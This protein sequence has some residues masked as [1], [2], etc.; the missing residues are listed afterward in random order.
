MKSDREKRKQENIPYLLLYRELLNK[1]M[2][3]ENWHSLATWTDGDYQILSDLILEKTK[4]RLSVSS[5]KRVMGKEETD[6]FPNEAT[7]NILVN[8]L[9]SNLKT[10]EEFKEK[11]IKEQSQKEI[12]VEN[13]TKKT[14]DID[15]KSESRFKKTTSWSLLA[16]GL[17]VA[18]AIS[19][20]VG[21]TVKQKT[22]H[23]SFANMGFSVATNG[24]Q[25]YCSKDKVAILFAV[26]L[27]GIVELNAY[28]A[29]PEIDTSYLDLCYTIESPS[30]NRIIKSLLRRS[31]SLWTMGNKDNP[32]QFKVDY[33]DI[34][35]QGK[36]SAVVD[37]QEH[38]KLHY[39]DIIAKKES[40]NYNETDKQRHYLV[41]NNGKWR[42]SLVE[43]NKNG[44][45]YID[46]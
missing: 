3:Q 15:K 29:L 34:V 40:Q 21:W 6:S 25:E 20:I 22:E 11:I 30:R 24:K 17:F 1:A 19:L 31:K 23:I 38:W 27:V 12:I 9:D 36:D 16:I 8:F 44:N 43:R 13:E 33:F 45:I 10:W 42:V 39:Y 5:L 7:L 46:N 37:T 4:S 18:L 32:S 26:Q 35:Y 14:L 41:K 28:R 2:E